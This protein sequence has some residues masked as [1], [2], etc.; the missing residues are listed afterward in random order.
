M[1]LIKQEKLATEG[2]IGLWKIEEEESFFLEALHLLPEEREQLDLIK[3]QRRRIEWL[4]AR[5]LVH[6]MSGRKERGAFIKDEFGK[7]H[8]ANSPFQIS[9]SHSEGMAAAV[10]S[11][12]A[13][14]IDIQTFV[15]KIER[16]ARKFM[17]QQE[18]D[19]LQATTRL[20]QLHIYWGGKEALYKAYGRRK[21]DFCTHILMEPFEQFGKKGTLSGQI[22]TDEVE[23]N[24][25]LFYEVFNDYFLVYAVEKNEEQILAP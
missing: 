5:L 12:Q 2:E 13:V 8:L 15:P 6:K 19:S 4:A 3:G 14:G 20:E 22:V 25:Q 7:P 18:L 16:L 9:I 10:A 17:R 1:G 21:L 24:F 11:P 23:M